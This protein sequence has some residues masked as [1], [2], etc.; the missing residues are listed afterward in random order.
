MRL[1]LTAWYSTVLCLMLIVYA[2][3]TYVA[4]R[5]EFFEQL[6]DQL[7]DDFETAEAFLVPAADGHIAWASD[8]DHDLDQDEDRGIDVWA[9]GGEP[10]YRAGASA[11]LPNAAFAAASA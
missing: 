3:A 8:R 11:T 1:R 6:E 7:H 5:H 4:V 2:T 10:I 9:S